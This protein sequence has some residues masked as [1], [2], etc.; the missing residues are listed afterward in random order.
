VSSSDARTNAP[1]TDYFI[2]G[3]GSVMIA[4]Q[5]SRSSEMSPYGLLISE[6]QRMTRKNGTLLF[7]PES[8]LERTMLTVVVGATRYR[9]RHED[10]TVAWDISCRCVVVRWHAGEVAITER[11]QVQSSSGNVVRDIL[12]DNPQS[13]A[14]T[15]ELPFY[16]NPLLF[17]TFGIHPGAT[18][19]ASGSASM[20]LYSI[21]A[22]RAFERFLQV[23]ARPFGSG[24]A[25][26]FLYSLEVPHSGPPAASDD[27]RP[28]RDHDSNDDEQNREARRL[29]DLYT[30]SR[31][32][33]R[34]A[35]S[36][37][38]RFDASIWQ[39]GMEWGMDA[40]MVAT[41]AA[42]S[43]MFTLARAILV[44]LLRK[45]TSD[46]GAIVEASRFRGG[47]MSEL[48]ANGATLDALWHYWRWSGDDTLIHTHWGTIATIADYPLRSE[49][50]HRSGMLAS[51][52]DFWE[53]MPWMGVAP[54]L[55]LGHQ[56]FC[57][58]GLERAAEIATAFGHYEEAG[59]W[60]E[61]SERIR[62][63]MIEDPEWAHVDDGAFIRR[64]LLDGS[65][66]RTLE[67]TLDGI[68]RL[69]A[70]YL[71]ERIDPPASPRLCEP[72]ITEAL[73]I[74][75]GMVDPKG[76]LARK[77][78]ENLRALWNPTGIGGYA[79]YNIA[80]DPDSPGPWP[81]ATA[82]VAAAEIEGGLVE[83][84][85]ETTAWLADRAGAGGSWLEYYGE[86][87]P[88][89][90]PVGIIVWGWAQYMLL[91]TRHLLGITITVGHIR[92]APRVSGIEHVIR[93]GSRSIRLS[94]RG[95]EH[96]TIDG[97]PAEM[98]DGGVVIMLPLQSDMVVE[99][100]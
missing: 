28:A 88:P 20:M 27:L 52:R 12:V 51:G 53:R 68:D 57:S 63:G 32:G 3:D 30:I 61:P 42:D 31:I 33:L 10:V 23:D 90:P 79:R 87:H 19:F 18:M 2:L 96:A 37:S 67:P 34:G 26:T 71:P 5:W 43:G 40:A 44:R 74:V 78:L 97:R 38:G 47:A 55:E 76:A 6:P 64:R 11:F 98:I 50:W 25:A 22:G 86:R 83:R 100:R 72:D 16:P 58:I 45:L 70:P 54:G 65:V 92:I 80:S 66:E 91:Y 17:D 77:T 15:L 60:S 36:Q 48:N 69:Y 21:P 84:G 29:E 89:Y 24:I 62:K 14:V 75:H 56:V 82:I 35:V 9:P 8:G 46:E 39:Y 73:P 85:L 49:Y 41:A 99:F 94:T 13:L 7:H 59:R 93:H 1:E 4:V 81:F 95:L